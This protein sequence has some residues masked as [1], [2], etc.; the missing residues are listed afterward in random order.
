MGFSASV[1]QKMGLE[2]K[3][4]GGEGGGEGVF[5]LTPSPL[6]CLPYVFFLWLSFLIL[7]SETTQ[8]CLLCSLQLKLNLQSPSQMPRFGGRLYKK[9]Q[10][11]AE[12]IY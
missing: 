7:F 8:K 3:N 4:E 5:F 1:V 12:S 9:N 11:F 2:P 6:F 10:A